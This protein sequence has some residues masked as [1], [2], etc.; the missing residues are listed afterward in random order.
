MGRTFKKN[1]KSKGGKRFPIG[2]EMEQDG[3][4]GSVRQLPDGEFVVN[5]RGGTFSANHGWQQKLSRY[6]PDGRGGFRQKWRVG[7]IANITTCPSPM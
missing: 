7:R 2:N 6:V 4:W 3:D 1:K 5:M